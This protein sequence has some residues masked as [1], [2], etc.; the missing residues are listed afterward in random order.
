MPSSRSGT[1]Q[2]QAGE[3]I[4]RL[5]IARQMTLTSVAELVGW[6]KSK[7]SRLETGR[8]I[9][10]GHHVD[11]FA[12]V[13][14]L[15]PAD[16]RRVMRLL[17]LEDGKAAPWWAGYESA[18]TPEYEDLIFLET[19]A[20]VIDTASTMVPGLLQAPLYARATLLQSPFVPDPDDA[21]ALLKV[22]Q[23]RQHVV[24]SGQVKLVATLS[25]SALA[26]A[27]CGREALRQQLAHLLKLSEMGN[28]QLR[29][30]PFDTPTAAFLGSVT[31][32]ELPDAPDAVV[33]V[34][35]EA[36]SQLLRDA[37][38]VK[39]YRRDLDYYRATAQDEVA[40]RAMITSRWEEL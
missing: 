9:I 28:V 12:N 32:L 31:I 19:H 14:S 13:L 17:G 30:V 10:D 23:R 22:R 35:Y 29:I 7:V 20:R 4:R 11:A 15:S 21:E 3:E 36:G 26:S 33:H 40:S 2:R 25:Q 24:T 39:R 6:D 38:L 1:A 18:L 16:K 5:R 34:A 8:M 27:F 37:R